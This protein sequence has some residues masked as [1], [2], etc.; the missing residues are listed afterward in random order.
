MELFHVPL[1]KPYRRRRLCNMQKPWFDY[2]DSGRYVTI[3]AFELLDPHF[4]CGLSGV[5]HSLIQ[6]L[7]NGSLPHS[8]GNFP[9][10]SLETTYLSQLRGEFIR[11]FPK[12]E[13]TLYSR[14]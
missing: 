4:C 11:V 13:L 2:L 1:A 7:N 8:M 6:A 12:I 14:K 3:P 5:L 9:L 10:L